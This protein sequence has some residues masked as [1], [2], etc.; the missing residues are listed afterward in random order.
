MI[1]LL[2]KRLRIKKPIFLN[3]IKCQIPKE[4]IENLI[5]N[6]LQYSLQMAARP[7]HTNKICWIYLS[8]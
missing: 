2:Q 8:R 7:S 4:N 1:N 3:L 5:Y 6:N